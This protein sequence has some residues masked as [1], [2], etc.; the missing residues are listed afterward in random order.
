VD[1]NT[2]QVAGGWVATHDVDVDAPLE[3]RIEERFSD[4]APPRLR[5]LGESAI[6]QKFIGYCVILS[7]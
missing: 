2:G 6:L 7:H 3:V 4:R 5:Y 1:E